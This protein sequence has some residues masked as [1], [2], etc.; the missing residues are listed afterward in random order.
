MGEKTEDLIVHCEQDWMVHCEQDWMVLMEC[1]CPMFNIRCV[2]LVLAG[3]VSEPDPPPP[4]AR[5]WFRD[6]SWHCTHS[7]INRVSI[8]S[9][10][11]ALNKLA[12]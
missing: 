10:W 3:I 1:E 5:V 11:I 8:P 4:H 9:E 2:D 6:Y 7:F 12:W